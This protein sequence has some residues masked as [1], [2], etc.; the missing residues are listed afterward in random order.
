MNK[1]QEE[2]IPKTYDSSK[3]LEIYELW[4]KSGY[5]KPEKV[6]EYLK[7]SKQ[8]VKKPFVMTLPPPNANDKL[9]IGHTCGYS[10]MDL[11]ARYNRM[12]GS[13]TLLIAGKDHASIQTE[14]VFTRKLEQREERNSIKGV[15]SI[16]WAM[17]STRGSRKRELDYRPIGIENFSLLIQD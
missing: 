3:E 16:V 6:E 11:L 13:P 7:N 9:H 4:E 2:Q 17:L 8:E 10:F 5:F 14:A 12:S 1:K 15:M